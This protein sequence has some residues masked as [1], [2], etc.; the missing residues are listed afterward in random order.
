MIKN[1]STIGEHLSPKRQ[2]EILFNEIISFRDHFFFRQTNID[3]NMSF[4]N[5]GGCLDDGIVKAKKIFNGFN[6]Y[7]ILEG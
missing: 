7:K 1:N 3:G 5:W 6:N 2:E 4:F